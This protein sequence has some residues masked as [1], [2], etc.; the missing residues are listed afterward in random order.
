M[1]VMTKR[2]ASP[3]RASDETSPE[4]LEIRPAECQN[5][6]SKIRPG[7]LP[8]TTRKHGQAKTYGSS[9]PQ[10][11]TSLNPLQSCRSREH[12]GQTKRMPPHLRLQEERDTW[13]RTQD[14]SAQPKWLPA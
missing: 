1:A 6:R 9:R 14:L 2:L 8:K 5:L 10:T 12:L 7:C 13:A 11:A 4:D 3:P